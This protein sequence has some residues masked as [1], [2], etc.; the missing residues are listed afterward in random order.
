MAFAGSPNNRVLVAGGSAAQV[1]VPVPQ[2]VDVS[3]NGYS[4]NLFSHYELT[5]IGATGSGSNASLTVSPG[6][7][8]AIPAQSNTITVT[9]S[10]T[11]DIVVVFGSL[12]S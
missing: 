11:S 6:A 7:V 12:N 10:A 9:S 4:G 2:I 3:G 8:F 5:A 1:V